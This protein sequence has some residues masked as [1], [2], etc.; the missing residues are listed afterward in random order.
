MPQL[1]SVFMNQTVTKRPSKDVIH[2]IQSEKPQVTT[3]TKVC[4]TFSKK[5]LDKTQDFWENI[6]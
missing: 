3:N 5:H 2:V 6:L 4:L 1:R